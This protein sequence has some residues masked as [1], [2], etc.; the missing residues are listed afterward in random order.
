MGGSNGVF[1]DTEMW[2]LLLNCEKRST[3]RKQAK[4]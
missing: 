3:E 4:N 2:V 1:S